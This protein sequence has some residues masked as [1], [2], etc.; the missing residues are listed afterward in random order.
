MKQRFLT[1]AAACLALASCDDQP[2]ASN[3]EFNWANDPPAVMAIVEANGQ[4]FPVRVEFH[5]YGNGVTVRN[6]SQFPLPS[7]R[8]AK[9]DERNRGGGQAPTLDYTWV[10]PSNR[11]SEFILT[12]DLPSGEQ[13]GY[14]S[15]SPKPGADR[16]AVA[17]DRVMP[18]PRA[19]SFAPAPPAQ[20]ETGSPS[21][22]LAGSPA[23]VG[24]SGGNAT[25]INVCTGRALRT[26]SVAGAL[27]YAQDLGGGE[28]LVAAASPASLQRYSQSS[29]AAALAAQLPNE[30]RPLG[31]ALSANG[32]AYVSSFTVQSSRLYAVDLAARRV[33]NSV[34]MGNYGTDVALSPDGTQV[35]ASS[36]FEDSVFVFDAA[37]L[38]P[39]ARV[40]GVVNPFGI[41]FSPDGTRAYI[42]SAADSFGSVKVVDTASFS[43]VATVNV[44]GM[45]RVVR[46]TPSGRHVFAANANSDFISQIDTATNRV[47]RTIRVGGNVMTL[48][49]VP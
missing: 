16:S 34:L 33:V 1:L 42:A 43:T 40:T 21:G 35:W 9:P 32:M 38:E 25:E 3:P 18:Y 12:D 15:P 10:L 2:L 13:L 26:V 19:L 24:F 29:G 8:Q 31:V 5:P 44:G 17:E 23:L 27:G 36:F 45:P 46:V 30:A 6:F 11:Q 47:V 7:A 39:V 28:F 48:A 49:L 41:D 37:T 22:C 14:G 4:Q 20:P